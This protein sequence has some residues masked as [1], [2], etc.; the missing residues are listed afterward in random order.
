MLNGDFTRSYAAKMAERVT[1][2]DRVERVWRNALGRAPEPDE[3]ARAEAFLQRN[4]LADLCLL[5][6]NMNEFLYVD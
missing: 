1:G 5:I 6:L 4:N 2:P 3:K